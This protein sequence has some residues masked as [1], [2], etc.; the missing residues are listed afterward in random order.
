MDRADPAAPHRRWTQG[1]I[2]TLRQAIG[3]GEPV[4]RIAEQLGR[5][6]DAVTLMMN[7]LRLR[8]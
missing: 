4:A 7:R 2:T 5:D 8:P 1:D 6:G 3:S